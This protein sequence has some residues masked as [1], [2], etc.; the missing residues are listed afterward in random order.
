M[1]TLVKVECGYNFKGYEYPL[2]STVYLGIVGE[3]YKYVEDSKVSFSTKHLSSVFDDV[4]ADQLPGLTNS[5][6]TA[7]EIMTKIKDF[8]DSNAVKVFQKYITSGG[9]NISTTTDTY[10][11]AT[12]SSLQNMTCWDLMK[13]LSEA[14]NKVC[15]I[16]QRGDFYFTAKATIQDSATYHFSGIGDS[17][18]TFGHN[19]IKLISVDDNFR[20]VYNRIRVQYDEEDTSTSYKIKK[21]DWAWGDSTSS[22]VFGVRTY[23][24]K[25]VFM[26][27]AKASET[28][29]SIY[30]EYSQPKKE[31]TVKTKY[32]PQLFVNDRVSLTYKTKRVE[33]D[34]LWG[35]FLWGYA[36]WGE[37]KG[38]NIN[39]ENQDFRITSIEHNFDNFSSKLI[40]REI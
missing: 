10:T 12:I 35:H 15:Y 3:D 1:K 9:W 21:E 30:N 33:G 29:I 31:V 37:R 11:F 6:Y 14:E 25:N 39:I 22:F 8:E 26:S 5:A 27:E 38:Y 24:Y 36:T 34:F 20:K 40:L 17:D 18:K 4:P 23:D 19:I 16:D 32:V 28:A 7:S 13:K 2:S